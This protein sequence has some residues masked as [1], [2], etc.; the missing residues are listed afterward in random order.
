MRNL[1]LS[2]SATL[3]R[4]S[5]ICCR[6]SYPIF[7]TSTSSCTTRLP[8]CFCKMVVLSLSYVGSFSKAAH[9]SASSSSLSWFLRVGVAALEKNT[10]E[11]IP[12]DLDLLPPKDFL[13]PHISM[14]SK[15]VVD[16][17]IFFLEL[18]LRTFTP[19]VK[20]L[21]KF[22]LSGWPGTWRVYATSISSPLLRMTI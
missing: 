4:L 8:V 1:S 14:P 16:M 22:P 15:D 20:W 19:S 10:S 5:I 17:A 12:N 9:L 11:P 3:S 18:A 6:S 2:S 13:L 7:L 21:Q